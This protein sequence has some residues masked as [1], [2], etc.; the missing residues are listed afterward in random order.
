MMPR[1][2]F[3]R[4][5]VMFPKSYYLEILRKIT[6]FV[7]YGQVFAQIIGILWIIRGIMYFYLE[8]SGVFLDK[9]CFNCV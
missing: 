7:Q 6:H 1:L 5:C 2:P 4:L 8:S 3:K 9:S